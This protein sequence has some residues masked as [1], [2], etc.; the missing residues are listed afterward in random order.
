[1]G[2]AVFGRY[3][4]LFACGSPPAATAALCRLRGRLRRLSLTLFINLRGYT[5]TAATG[6]RFPGSCNLPAL[7]STTFSAPDTAQRL[8][9]S[10][11]QN[12][13]GSSRVTVKLHCLLSLVVLASGQTPP[14]VSHEQRGCRSRGGAYLSL[15]SAFRMGRALP[16]RRPAHPTCFSDSSASAQVLSS[17][18]IGQGPRAGTL[19][20]SGSL[21]TAVTH[22]Q[23]HLTCESRD[24]G[25][26]W[27]AVHSRRNSLC[28]TSYNAVLL[29]QLKDDSAAYI[30]VCCCCPAAA[31]G[32][33]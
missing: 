4:S 8:L 13:L 11:R 10:S 21:C 31:R 5:A 30:T 26:Q 1:M 16:E 18:H 17:P 22:C 27:V 12:P 23:L 33:Y 19:G 6:A 32:C 28:C 2:R 3:N 29:L 7:Y 20:C 25:L 15:G 14:R 9:M 24:K